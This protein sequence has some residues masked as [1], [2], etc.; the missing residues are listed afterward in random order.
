MNKVL[1]GDGSEEFR[2]TL[3]NPFRHGECLAC[4]SPFKVFIRLVGGAR[5]GAL[6]PLYYC[7]DCHTFSCL[8]EYEESDGQLA[9]D[10]EYNV[11]QLDFKIRPFDLLAEVLRETVG[12]GSHADVGCGLGILVDRCAQKGIKSVGYDLN[13]FAIARGRQIYPHLELHDRSIGEDGLQYDL[14]TLIDVLEHIK[15]PGSFMCKVVSAIAPGGHLY[16]VVPLV[17]KDSWVHLSEPIAHQLRPR[18]ETPFRDNDVHVVHYS[19]RGLAALGE[20]FGLTVV[21]DCVAK[22][23]PANGIL[24]RKF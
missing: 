8:G 6:L 21:R 3:G 20:R 10:V 9:D 7:M 14:I 16:V 5:T 23:W 13:R 24:F 17:N 2:L 19:S 11:R 12:S 18:A 4:N 1:P 15:A 22:P